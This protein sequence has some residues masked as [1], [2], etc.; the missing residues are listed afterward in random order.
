[1]PKK[2]KQLRL[3]ERIQKEREE[4]I[5]PTRLKPFKRV[6]K[7]VIRIQRLRAGFYKRRQ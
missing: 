1:M 2:K 4:N 3:G 5:W 6:R 7:L